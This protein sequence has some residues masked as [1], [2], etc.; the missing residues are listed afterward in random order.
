MASVMVYYFTQYNIVTDETMHS[1][2][3]AM[4]EAIGKI[5]NAI[6][7]EETAREV[8]TSRLDGDGFYT[9]GPDGVA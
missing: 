7:L 1:A 4:L 3:P 6:V 9:P 2:R 8:D 5:E